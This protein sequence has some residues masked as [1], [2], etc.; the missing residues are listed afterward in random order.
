MSKAKR[1]RLTR[2][3][4]LQRTRDHVEARLLSDG[5]L[6]TV[7]ATFEAVGGDWTLI[8]QILG[9][10]RTSADQQPSRE[11]T[12]RLSEFLVRFEEFGVA[13][14]ELG[15]RLDQFAAADADPVLRAKEKR[16]RECARL[17]ESA[18]T[19]QVAATRSI[20]EAFE[21]HR[22][23]I[24]DLLI[25]NINDVIERTQIDSERVSQA[26][27]S[28]GP[29]RRIA[30]ALKEM[31]A[32]GEAF[33]EQR[34]RESAA[35]QQVM[36]PSRVFADAFQKIVRARSEPLRQVT[37]AMRRSREPLQRAIEETSVLFDKAR[38][39]IPFLEAELGRETVD[40]ITIEELHWLDDAGCFDGD[41]ARN[42]F[43]ERVRKVLPSKFE[44]QENEFLSIAEVATELGISVAALR[45]RVHRHPSD[46]SIVP[47]FEKSEIVARGKYLIRRDR[48]EEW[49]RV[50]AQKA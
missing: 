29:G 40:H 20:Q 41:P 19:R 16:R 21:K 38:S 39:F 4:R 17:V 18:L 14:E 5:E 9:E 7:R 8:R 49:R 23:T 50:Y 42:E 15:R 27:G 35:L 10:Y 36:E 30:E 44:Q 47:P 13:E 28:L 32:V 46:R 37:E 25:P 34:Q 45:K 33:Q 43:I 12:E 2:E 31:H 3:E 6:P 26:L 1:V 22:T 11:R 24:P 48:F